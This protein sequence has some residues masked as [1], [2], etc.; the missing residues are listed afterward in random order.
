MSRTLQ[1][2]LHGS[3]VG[4]LTQDKHGR[5]WFAYGRAWL[6]RKDAVPLSH[7]L[8]LREERFRETECEG[9][10]AGVLPEGENR[11]RVAEVLGVSAENHFSLLAEIGGEC[12]GAVTF[13]PPGEDLAQLDPIYRPLSEGELAEILR[14]LPTRPLLAGKKD[15]RLSLAGAQNKLAVFVDEKGISLPLNGAPSTH[16]LKPAIERFEG[17]VENERFCLDLAA[18][19]GLPTAKATVGQCEEIPYLLVERYDR[20]RSDSDQVKRL[21]QEDFCQT[22]GLPP[23]LKYENEGGPTLEDCFSLVRE[24]SSAPAPDLLALLDGVV[25]HYLIGNNDAHG[26]NYSFLYRAKGGTR[27]ARLA[28]FYDL[29]STIAYPDLSPKMAMRIGK[30]YLPNQVR[31]EHW[32]AMWQQAGFPATA[33]RKRG[34]QFANR[35]GK[36]VSERSLESAIERAIMATV[37]ARAQ[38]LVKIWS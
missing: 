5:L 15:V 30:K 29:I 9:F 28:P 34:I 18:A 35:M 13:L 14:E 8:P 37:S 7:S 11:R 2:Y 27:S 25:F 10:F 3:S 21:H 20:E 23:R 6:K 17:L 19:A 22:L 16:I 38:R 4:E 32:E 12:A 26:K 24:I 1:V 33:A 31:S 36:L